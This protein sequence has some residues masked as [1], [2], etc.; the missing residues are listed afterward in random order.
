SAAFQILQQSRANAMALPAV[1][2][3]QAE[4]EAVVVS[5][6]GVAGFADDGL[7]PVDLHGRDDREAVLYADMGEMIEHRL[8]QFAHRAKKAVVARAGR[9]RA[10]IVLQ[11]FRIT[12]LDKAH[13]Y[14]VAP[15]R[16]QHVGILLEVIEP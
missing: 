8:R 11:F 12:R 4:L 9:E 15:A 5:V 7:E 14:R 3:R 6:E 16:A 13:A 2:D 1:V 10:E